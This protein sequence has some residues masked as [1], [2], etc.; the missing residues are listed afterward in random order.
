MVGGP[1]VHYQKLYKMVRSQL[2]HFHF[3]CQSNFP[4][5]DDVV[6]SKALQWGAYGDQVMVYLHL[7]KDCFKHDIN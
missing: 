7:I 2:C 3:Q 1:V 5:C 6:T 4:S